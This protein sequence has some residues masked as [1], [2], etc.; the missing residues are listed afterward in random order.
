MLGRVFREK[1]II[2]SAYSQ[3]I[4][5]RVW[6]IYTKSNKML[7][8]SIS[9]LKRSI[10][11]IK[12]GKKNSRA[13]QN[14][15]VELSLEIANSFPPYTFFVFVRKMVIWNLKMGSKFPSKCMGTK[16]HHRNRWTTHKKWLF[17]RKPFQEAR[18]RSL[19]QGLYEP[20]TWSFRWSI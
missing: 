16:R 1:N 11:Q 13:L 6:R 12:N 15:L 4:Y 9:N 2:E 5:T 17:T 7:L 18:I 10:C 14:H 20:E 8:P 19:P 3:M